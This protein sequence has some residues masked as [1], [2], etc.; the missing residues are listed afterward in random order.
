MADSVF[1]SPWFVIHLTFVKDSLGFY[2]ASG[3][4]LPRTQSEMHTTKFTQA[5]QSLGDNDFQSVLFETEFE[6]SSLGSKALTH[7]SFSFP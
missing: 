2:S 4:Y 1:L 5:E 7:I 3:V 6:A